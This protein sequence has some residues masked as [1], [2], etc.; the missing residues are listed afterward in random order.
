MRKMLAFL[1]EIGMSFSEIRKATKL[2]SESWCLRD[3][4]TPLN[5]VKKALKKSNKK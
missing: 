3:L 4:D 2:L 5:G 1:K